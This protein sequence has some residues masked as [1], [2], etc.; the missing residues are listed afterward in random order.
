MDDHVELDELHVASV[1]DMGG[2]AVLTIKGTNGA[3]ARMDV[4][5][6]LVDGFEETVAEL[7]MVYEGYEP[8]DPEVLIAPDADVLVGALDG[9]PDGAEVG[10]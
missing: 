5:E 8:D 7:R 3:T 10:R 1:A 9:D 6:D 2:T 4:P